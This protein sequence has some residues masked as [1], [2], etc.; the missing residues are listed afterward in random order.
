MAEYQGPH[1]SPPMLRSVRL[2]LKLN[3]R[4]IG[5]F[6]LLSQSSVSR[7]EVH[8][9]FPSADVLPPDGVVTRLAGIDPDDQ[10]LAL[11]EA[12]RSDQ[13]SENSD[14]MPYVKKEIKTVSLY[15]EQIQVVTDVQLDLSRPVH[16]LVTPNVLQKR[17][18]RVVANPF[19]LSIDSWHG[20][21]RAD[22]GAAHTHLTYTERYETI[23][24][25]GH[26]LVRAISYPIGNLVIRISEPLAAVT[27]A[28]QV[29]GFDVNKVL[30]VDRALRGQACR[31]VATE[32]VPLKI[33]GHAAE[34]PRPATGACYG[35]L[36]TKKDDGRT[37]QPQ[38]QEAA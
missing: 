19:G 34:W 31:E 1:A 6:L 21:V 26:G 11:A 12:L 29:V 24:D 27:V 36:I 38:R 8:G 35:I 5:E 3:Q 17:P 7:W 37:L 28:H 2:S 14:S 22:S 15:G 32:S 25:F 16:P 18:P 4:Q 20:E 33:W 23:D 9:D 10:R 13:A 30:G